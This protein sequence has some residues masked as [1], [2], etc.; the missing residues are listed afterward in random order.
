METDHFISDG[1][2]MVAKSLA[3]CG[4]VKT[5]IRLGTGDTI[6]T[7][8]LQGRFP[9]LIELWIQWDTCCWM[10]KGHR[11]HIGSIS[12]K[13]ESLVKKDYCCWIMIG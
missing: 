6:L 12:T 4:K 13:L 3:T 2:S 9:T 8:I 1:F 5:L 10:I 7:C 11:H